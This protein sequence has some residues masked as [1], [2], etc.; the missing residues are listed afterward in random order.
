MGEGAQSLSADAE[1]EA[2]LAVLRPALMKYAFWLCRSRS[3]AE[4]LVQETMLRA[5]R[6][7][8]QLRDPRALKG[9]LLTICRREHAR[10][11]E[12]RQVPTIC[13]DDV[14]DDAQ[15]VVE[16]VDPAQISEVRKAIL[17]LDPL[18]CVPL[19]MQVIEGRT[20]AE[21][22]AHLG[23]PR[24]TILTRLFRARGLLRERLRPIAV[25]QGR[26]RQVSGESDDPVPT[27][28]RD[29]SGYWLSPAVSGR[30]P[31]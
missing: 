25:R 22:A 31:A 1:F 20:T 8:G 12:R 29:G 26:R 10:A 24:Q 11:F 30:A 28:N 18:Y 27:P 7:R 6:S 4:G 15:P 19:I 9:W 23:V 14:P 17:A 2:Q 3:V 13:I 16:D 21:I 5:W